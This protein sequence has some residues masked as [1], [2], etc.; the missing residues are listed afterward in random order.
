MRRLLRWFGYAVAA[1][2][3]VNLFFL[4]ATHFG[5]PWWRFDL[6]VT[7]NHG[8]DFNPALWCVALGLGCGPFLIRDRQRWR[9]SFRVCTIA[10]VGAGLAGVLLTF[11]FWAEDNPYAR[12][13]LAQLVAASA[14]LWI[15]AAIA[16][17]ISLHR[18]VDRRIAA[19]MIIT[20]FWLLVLAQRAIWV[21]QA[22]P[23]LAR[24]T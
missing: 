13:I 18:R 23:H 24:I 11:V 21:H 19:A 16:L 12:G 8:D 2:G 1:Y 17:L 15:T 22:I 4:S 14:P 5:L 3:A 9:T 10:Y 20:T 6:R 7:S